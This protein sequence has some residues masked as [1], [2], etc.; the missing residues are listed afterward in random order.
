VLHC[1]KQLNKLKKAIDESEVSL[2][3]SVFTNMLHKLFAHESIPFTGEPLSGLQVLGILETRNI[4]FE[5]VI[6][7]SANE[8]VLPKSLNVPSFIPY[9]LR[10]GFGLP[11]IEQHEAVYAYYFYRLLQRAKKISLV[12]NTKTDEARTGEMG[13]YLMQLKMESGHTIRES[14]VS[15]HIDRKETSP[16]VVQKDE[17]AMAELQ[18]Y[19]VEEEMENGKWKME[20]DCDTTNKSQITNRKSQIKT[21]SPSAINAYLSCSLR[22]YF[23]YIAHLKIPDEMTEDVDSRLL[24]NLLHFSIKTLYES[25][26]GNVVN[27]EDLQTLVDNRQ[28]IDDALDA[29]LAKEY[30]CSNKLPEEAADNGK[31]LLLRDV[32]LK[33]I[34]Q[35][36]QHDIARAPFTLEEVEK[37]LKHVF[38]FT[39][40][41]S[42]LHICLGGI[43]DRKERQGN[44]VSVIDYKTGKVKN[45]FKSVEALFGNDPK[46]HNAGVLQ[47]MLYSVLLK[48][49]QSDTAFIPKLYFLRELYGNDTD[50]LI[51]DKSSKE[52]ITSIT[53]Y[54][55]TL[56]A[57]LGN[58]LGELYNPAQPFVQT[59][60]L[61]TCKYCDYREI[62]SR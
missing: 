38:S 16:I 51:T 57:A 54:M 56:T 8:G 40:G 7:L 2:S 45:D 41:S 18:K 43:I 14:S 39:A 12:Y 37:E 11:A 13:R 33:Y 47:V 62:C 48:L 4:D 23:R 58:M 34:R 44:T 46:Q 5:H 3:L 21:L 55:D 29:A 53:P 19:L 42:A 35:I 36:I 31:L 52:K 50:F 9:N 17:E 59:T 60:D 6:L 24:G 25:F 32:V 27:T 61:D 10:R 15:F 49:K 1:S 20:N 22:F 30:Y 28:K 26:E